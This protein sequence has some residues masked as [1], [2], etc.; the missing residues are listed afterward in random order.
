MCHIARGKV[1]SPARGLP[2]KSSQGHH[3]A[4]SGSLSWPQG[5]EKGRTRSIV[6]VRLSCWRW[7][8]DPRR[9]RLEFVSVAAAFVPR[10]STLH[11]DVEVD[12]WK[13]CAIDRKFCYTSV[14]KP[15]VQH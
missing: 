5:S 7:A 12:Q 6:R 3:S 14:Q 15:D 10:L 8:A 13:R 2:G 9:T 1:H 4:R 11:T